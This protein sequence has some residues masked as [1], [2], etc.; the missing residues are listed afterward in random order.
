MN[1]I[2]FVVMGEPR[3][4]T[5]FVK[6]GKP[7]L[8]FEAMQTWQELIRIEAKS[9]MKGR[10]PFT[11]PIYLIVLFCR[12]FPGWAPKG[13]AARSRWAAKHI[14]MKPDRG[15]YLKACEDAMNNICYLD[16]NQVV[17]AISEKVYAESGTFLVQQP[18]NRA[19]TQ[20][21]VQAPQG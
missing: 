16:D 2:D 14:L 12:G 21:V 5:V 8:G 10:E 7:S 9:A 18:N 19:Y 20:I 11:G 15:N 13:A 1:V 3:P 4:W 6:M 17:K